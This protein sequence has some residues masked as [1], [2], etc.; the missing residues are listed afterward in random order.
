MLTIC[1]DCH[2]QWQFLCLSA[3]TPG[4]DQFRGLKCSI[5]P[6]RDLCSRWLLRV[7]EFIGHVRKSQSSGRWS[8]LFK[9]SHTTPKPGLKHRSLKVQAKTPGLELHLFRLAEACQPR[10]HQEEDGHFGSRD[11][12]YR[13]HWECHHQG[14]L[15]GKIACSY[16]SSHQKR[17]EKSQSQGACLTLK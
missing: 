1:K 17:L 13:Y 14:L 2:G 6:S 4:L 11:G 16:C 8:G 5:W 3:P 15:V 9:V 10:S 7:A 12:G